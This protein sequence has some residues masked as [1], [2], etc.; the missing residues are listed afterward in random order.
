VILDTNGN[1]FGGFTPGEWNG[2]HGKADNRAKA[3]NSQK[4]F[5]FTVTNPRNIPPRRFGM[6]AVRK[7]WAIHCRS[8]S[9]PDFR[10]ICVADHWKVNT[11][12]F[13]YFDDSNDSYTNDTGPNGFSVFAC[14]TNG[15]ESTD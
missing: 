1:I 12:S 3:N 11:N 14:S 7:H 6:N 9:G 5:L 15:F 4:S 2:N 13:A 10:D 8:A